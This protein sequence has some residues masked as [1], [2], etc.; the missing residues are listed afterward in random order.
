MFMFDGLGLAMAGGESLVLPAVTARPHTV[1]LYAHSCWFFPDAKTG[2]TSF[3]VAAGTTMATNFNLTNSAGRV[4]GT[5]LVNGFPLFSARVEFRPSNGNACSNNAYTDSGGAFSRLLSPGPYVADVFGPSG[6]IGSF[7]FFSQVGEATNVDTFTTPEGTNVRTDL[8]GGTTAVG[9]L[10]LQFA[11]VNAAGITTVVKSGLGPPPATGY[12]ILGFEGAPTY[13]DLT[14]TAAYSGDITVCI[15]YNPTDVKG[16]ENLLELHHDDGTG[17]KKVRNM[18]LDVVMDVVCGDTDSLSPFVIVEPIVGDNTPPAV[19]VPANLALEATGPGGAV[20]TFVAAATDAEDGSPETICA[21]ASGST[22]A[23]GTTPVTCTATDGGGLSASASFTVTVADTAKPAFTGVP[24]KIIAYATSR[25]GAL[26]SYT[27]PTASD[28]VYGS[29]AVTCAARV[30]R[31]VPARHDDGHLQLVRRKRQRHLRQR[32]PSGF[33]TRRPPTARSSSNR[34]APTVA[35]S[36]DRPRGAGEV[37]DLRA[38]APGSR[39]S[40]RTSP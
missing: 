18:M 40:S 34:F 9:G 13:W 32:S 19:T 38:R 29:S 1:G 39:T 20:A 31:A 27:A 35:P 15:H 25:K 23:I 17:F 8:G 24:D 5:I 28:A 6:V 3:T 30:G 10:A 22:F 2:E 33:S 12:R 7:T 11:R 36:S 37:P 16:K 26:V 14:T 21:P 4:K